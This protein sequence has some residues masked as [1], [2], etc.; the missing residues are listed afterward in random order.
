MKGSVHQA[1]ILAWGAAD[2]DTHS[3]IPGDT[4]GPPGSPGRSSVCVE[5]GRPRS[6]C[7]AEQ[8]TGLWRPRRGGLAQERGCR[9]AALGGSQQEGRLWSEAFRGI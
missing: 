2:V 3:V 5:S 4:H 7:P 1:S 8:T 9:G 6:A